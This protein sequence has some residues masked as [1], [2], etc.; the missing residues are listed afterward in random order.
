M[1]AY[2]VI[3]KKRDGLVLEKKE[4]EFI[5]NG[6][7]SGEVPDYQLSAFLMAVYFKGMTEEE[8]TNLTLS[9]ANSGEKLDF[10]SIKGVRADKHSTG[11]VGDKTSL[12]VTPIVS[13]LG[14]KVAKMSGR[15]LGHT[16]GT[17]DKLESIDG[18]KVDLSNED[19]IKAVNYCGAAIIGQTKNLAPA[20][21]IL[22]SLRDVTATVDSIPLIAS[23]IMGKKL[24]CGDDVIVL[25]V[26]TGNGAFIKDVSPCE[27]LA[28]SMVCAG[29]M[30]N[31]KICAIL[32]DMSR[33]LGRAVG[34][35]LEVI[36]AIEVLKGGGEERLKTLS[37]RLAAEILRLS[38]FGNIKECLK[39]A[40]ESIKNGTA[41][42][43]FKSMVAAQGGDVSLIDDV[44]KFKRA[45]YEWTVRAQK[46]G[47]IT[48]VDTEI[49]GLAALNLGAG[50][51]KAGDK[52]DLSAGLYIKREVGDYVSVGEEILTLFSN[53]ESSIKRSENLI[54]SATNIGDEKP[55]PTPVII[56]TI[57]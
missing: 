27:K 23:S 22:Y 54:L 32:S 48:S 49:Y 55:L 46:S 9:I 33:P 24:A 19:F 21:K 25:D 51:N 53:D 29:K 18:F 17:V 11:G 6:A 2:D 35:S 8:T 40:E 1:R 45:K 3:K 5:V 47:Y 50:R 31:K 36:E 4:I 39:L 7:V 20:D 41:L 10:S 34:N 52:I 57:E 37:L 56:K 28:K 42:S 16:G 38:N 26:K 13:S 43:A 44:S 12:I 15:G 30:A 14:V